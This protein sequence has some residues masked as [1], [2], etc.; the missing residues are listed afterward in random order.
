MRSVD[1]EDD[2]P[3]P[4]DFGKP[5]DGEDSACGKRDMRESKH[6]GSRRETRDDGMVEF[7]RRSSRHRKGCAH[8]ERAGSSGD[9]L[10]SREATDVFVVGSEDLLPFFQLEAV[11]HEAA[12]FGGV[13]GQH[14]PLG[15]TA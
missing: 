4:A 1:H 6:P 2:P 5:G 11:G 7:V 9:Q 8:Q 3:L 10:P 14:E 12:P 15:V 13:A